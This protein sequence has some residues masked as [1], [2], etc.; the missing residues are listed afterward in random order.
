[1]SRPQII[2]VV[3]K[4]YDRLKEKVSHYLS[5]RFLYKI[6]RQ[7]LDCKVRKNYMTY[8]VFGQNSWQRPASR[9]SQSTP[10]KTINCL[11]RHVLIQ[12][13]NVSQTIRKTSDNR[14]LG[15][16]FGASALIKAKILWKFLL[17]TCFTQFQR[18]VLHLNRRTN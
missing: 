11:S 14:K 15:I 1:M 17:L 12:Q 18:N 10:H 5:D 8:L 16:C 7:N 9:S 3:T 2:P 6:M 13:W 4:D